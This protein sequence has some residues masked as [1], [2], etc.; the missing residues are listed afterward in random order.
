MEEIKAYKTESGLVF[1]SQAEA[2][3]QEILDAKNAAIASWCANHLY[4]GITPDEIEQE[5]I[6]QINPLREALCQDILALDPVKIVPSIS[7]LSSEYL[8]GFELGVAKVKEM[9]RND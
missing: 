6:E 5:I 7:R 3:R 4:R 2:E 8:A 1:E 9:I